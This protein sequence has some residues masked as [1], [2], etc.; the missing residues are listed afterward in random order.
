MHNDSMILTLG[1]LTA[2]RIMP[3]AH[4]KIREHILVN[5]VPNWMVLLQFELRITVIQVGASVE[6]QSIKP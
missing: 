3:L 1:S 5:S 2:L 6:M 4:Y